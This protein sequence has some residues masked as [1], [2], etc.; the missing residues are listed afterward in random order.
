MNECSADGPT[1]CFLLSRY[2]GQ[3]SENG[4]VSTLEAVEAVFREMGAGEELSATLLV[5]L[6]LRVEAVRL[7]NGRD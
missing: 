5:N 1:L 2:R 6:K 3:A 4:R 7:Q